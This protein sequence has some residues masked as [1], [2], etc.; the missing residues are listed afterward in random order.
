[1]VPIQLVDQNELLRMM[2]DSSPGA[3]DDDTYHSMCRQCGEIVSHRLRA[4]RSEEC[5]NG[6]RVSPTLD[7]ESVILASARPDGSFVHPK[8]VHPVRKAI[9]GHT[10]PVRDQL[11]D[12]GGRW[13]PDQKAW[14][15]PADKA[16]QA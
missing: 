9:I 16:E 7:V 6:H 11:R 15:V 5:R 2:F 1:T 3:A 13:S 4:A 12:L 10:Y 14:M 8:T